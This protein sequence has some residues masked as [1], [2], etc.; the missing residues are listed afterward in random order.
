MNYLNRFLH[1]CGDEPP[2]WAFTV[3]LAPSSPR[4]WRLTGSIR[5][6]LSMQGV[7][8][9]RMEIDRRRAEARSSSFLHWRGDS[10]W[11]E[12]DETLVS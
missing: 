10:P 9:T 12:A 6:F 2:D 7:F 4:P 3:E 1:V 8:S 11:L 5:D